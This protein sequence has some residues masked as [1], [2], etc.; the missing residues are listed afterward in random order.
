MPAMFLADIEGSFDLAG[1]IF[2]DQDSAYEHD[3]FPY[4]LDKT[5]SWKNSSVVI[6]GITNSTK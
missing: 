5:Q 4:A 6:A 2:D 3:W 1:Q